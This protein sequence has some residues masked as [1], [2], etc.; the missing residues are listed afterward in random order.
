MKMRGAKYILALTLAMAGASA[1]AHNGGYE[2]GNLV[3][4]AGY[5]GYGED[6]TETATPTGDDALTM[7]YAQCKALKS[8]DLSQVGAI[9][10]A[11]FAY[12]AVTSI[13][14][15]A[16]ISSVGYISFG[17]CSNLTEVSCNSWNW[18]NGTANIED[19]EPFRDCFKLTTLRVSGD[20]ASP[21]ES[22][23]VTN[24]FD[25]L[26]TVYC[27]TSTVSAWEAAYPSLTIIGDPELAPSPAPAPAPVHT[28][29]SLTNGTVS[30]AFSL[31]SPDDA[32]AY[33]ETN[34]VVVLTGDDEEA[35]LITNYLRAVIAPAAN[36]GEYYAYVDV[37]PDT[38]PAPIIGS[39]TDSPMPVVQYSDGVKVDISVCNAI[40]GLWYG[41]EVKDSLSDP[42]VYDVDS[43]DRAPADGVVV[44]PCTKRTS[45]A[46]FFRVRVTAT[47][48]E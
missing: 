28:L 21:P 16:N 31:P 30:A 48:P 22:F 24:T 33:A 26:T 47:K 36:E 2:N 15:T 12:S 13:V 34:I 40:Q 25:V 7:L 17:G 4:V 3:D 6:T 46:A 35:G 23:S 1:L 43:F 37:N 32:D 5:A 45:E 19:K 9:G 44:I 39:S 27:P 41:C 38:V 10:D 14:L 8:L 42:F 20:A 11:A 18:A 29:L